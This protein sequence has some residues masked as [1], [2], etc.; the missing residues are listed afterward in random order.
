MESNGEYM[1]NGVALII[2]GGGCHASGVGRERD[3]KYL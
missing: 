1:D 3:M 2:P